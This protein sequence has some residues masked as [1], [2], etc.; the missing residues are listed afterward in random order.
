MSHL[1]CRLFAAAWCLALLAVLPGPRAALAAAQ[2][3]GPAN[4]LADGRCQTLVYS[5]NPNY[6]PYDW[7]VDDTRFEGA[8]IELLKMAAPPG[9]RLKPVVYPWKRAL[10]L[11]RMGE[12][13]LLVSLRIT[14]ERSAFL[15]FTTHRA[16]PNPIV[17]FVPRERC[18]RFNTWADL[19]SKLGGISMGDT[20]GGGFDQ[21]LRKELHFEEAQGME[22]NFQ[23]LA[24]GRIDYFVTSKYVGEAYAATHAQ[25]HNFVA[26]SPPISEQD[27]YFGFSKA[28][29]CAGLLEQMSQRLKELD[30]KGVPEKLLKR[31]L[32]RLEERT[33]ELPQ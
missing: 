32:H 1:A 2:A 16:F 11:A 22:Q 33:V 25:K 30:R 24:A 19:K 18:F 10:E 4:G 8:S 20:F 7:A 21:Y 29:P 17:V 6:P 12:I 5:T 14:P 15:A 3:E 23:K 28:S 9:V 31:Y 13:D 27:I 26:L